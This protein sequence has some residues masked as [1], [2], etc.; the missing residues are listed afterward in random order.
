MLIRICTMRLLQRSILNWKIDP[1]H[2][3]GELY[4]SYINEYIEEAVPRLHKENA[5]YLKQIDKESLMRWLRSGLVYEK[6]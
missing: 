3:D 2:Y 5:E 6:I 1:R 4:E